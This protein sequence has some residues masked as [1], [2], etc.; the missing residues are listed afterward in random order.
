MSSVPRRLWVPVQVMLADASMHGPAVPFGGR[1][2]QRQIGSVFPARSRVR[3]GGCADNRYL[4]LD[5]CR[6]G[7]CPAGIAL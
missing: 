6:P 4:E 5:R 2:G 7:A 1:Q 3:P